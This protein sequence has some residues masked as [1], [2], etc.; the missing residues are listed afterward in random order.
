MIEFTILLNDDSLAF[1]PHQYAE[2][3]QLFFP[4]TARI[5]RDN[6]VV[7]LAPIPIHC[8][9]NAI[10]FGHWLTE[11]HNLSQ[12]D[13]FVT[14]V[15]HDMFKA[16]LRMRINP[17]PS[18]AP[19]WSHQTDFFFNP[20]KNRIQAAGIL[21]D[22]QIAFHIASMHNKGYR[23][24]RVHWREAVRHEGFTDAGT[25]QPGTRNSWDWPM[26]GLTVRLQPALSNI[27]ALAHIKQAFIAAYVDTIRAEFPDVFNR[28]EAVS[29]RYEFVD[30]ATLTGNPDID[31][32]NLCGQSDVRL[33]DRTLVIQTFIGS[34]PPIV[35]NTTIR[36][37]FWLLLT[38][39]QDPTSILFPVPTHHQ[40]HHPDPYNTAFVNTV[41]TDFEGH[42]RHLLESASPSGP[43]A[44]RW[45]NQIDTI[46]AGLNDVCHIFSTTDYDT[47]IKT[48]S[49][50][51]PTTFCTMC[52]SEIPDDFA[53]SPK[54]D[55]GAS[56]GN[57]TDWHIGAPDQTCVLCAIANFK[58]PPALEQARRLIFQRKIV[59]FATTTPAAAELQPQKPKLPFFDASLTFNPQLSI[60]S[61]ESLITLNIIG[62][63]YLHDTC[64]RVG[65]NHPQDGH[66]LLW[67][68]AASED[69]FTFIGFIGSDKG[70]GRLLELLTQLQANLSRPVHL[71]DSILPMNIEVPFQSLTAVLGV[72][73]GR[74]FQL[75]Y[76][77]LTTSNW[78][79]TIPIIWEGYHLVDDQ[80]LAAA[81]QLS[82]FVTQ[83]KSRRVN[84]R[85][86]LTA[87]ADSPAAFMDLLVEQ[88]GYNYERI[89][90]R[91][92]TLSGN[93]DPI[94]YLAQLRESIRRYPI[95]IEL[96]G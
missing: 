67:L 11:I 44:K 4:P 80:A 32:S 50:A 48:R 96:W 82:A 94:A 17:S 79:G 60:V 52:G 61:L 49:P 33:E 23:K 90:D 47:A 69:P 46:I 2:Q 66:P 91:L 93:G 87:L 59:Y 28:Y 21:D 74:H 54:R 18:K 3:L 16:I 22:F 51:S 42:F 30:P 29:Y 19:L 89:Y 31:A 53:C 6:D 92:H 9:F 56:V 27:V 8:F 88:G 70:K 41:K 57:Y 75:K 77:P 20:I 58:T 64:R 10:T 84:H 43:A 25:E 78:Q 71:L 26:L 45:P 83:F 13:A 65:I 40:D 14:Y 36:L 37:P 34:Q 86:K 62:A 35:G 85:M 63:L 1:E 38:L 15:I 39:R 73:K 81:R 12:N 7:H 24:K 55:L 76:K 68:E 72:S 95:I 5:G